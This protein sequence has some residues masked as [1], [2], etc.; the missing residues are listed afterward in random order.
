MR[1]K[2][3]RLAVAAGLLTFAQGAQAAY[4]DARAFLDAAAQASTALVQLP[5]QS[6]VITDF[7]GSYT[8]ATV[9]QPVTVGASGFPYNDP[10]LTQNRSFLRPASTAA[11]QLG[12]SFGCLSPTSNCLGAYTITYMLPFPIIGLAGNMDFGAGSSSRASLTDI[13]FFEFGPRDVD[14]VSGSFRQYRGFWGDIFAPTD[15]ITV[16]WTPGLLSTDDAAGF[17]LTDAQVLVAPGFV[18]V[19]EPAAIALFG[20]GLLGL[21]LTRRRAA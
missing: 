4:L 6:V 12:G 18:T 3:I 20:I 14:P 19:P 21:A 2:T 5:A 10:T 15:T 9:G 16:T 17:R 11:G 7:F 13:P 1:L 8:P